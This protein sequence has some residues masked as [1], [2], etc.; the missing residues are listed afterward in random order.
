MFVQLFQHRAAK[1]GLARADF[2]GELDKTLPLADAVEQ[3]VE[4]LAML[5]AVKQESRVRRNVERRALSG[6]NIPGTRWIFSR[7]SAARSKSLEPGAQGVKQPATVPQYLTQGAIR[8]QPARIV[9]A[10]LTSASASAGVPMVMR[11]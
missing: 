5:R 9:F 1:R 7:T 6:R 3:M 4:R 8:L 10:A 2:A 11:K